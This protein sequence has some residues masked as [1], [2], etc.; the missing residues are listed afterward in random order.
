MRN[1]GTLIIMSCSMVTLVACSGGNSGGS[2]SSGSTSYGQSMTA[3]FIDAP[4]KGLKFS[5]ENGVNS[6]TGDLGKFSCKRGEKISFSLGGLDLGYAACGDKIFVQD[7]VSSAT[8]YN[9]QQAAAVLQTFSINKGTYLDLSLI[10]QNEIDLSGLSYEAV[11]ANLDLSSHLT[12]ALGSAAYANIP[13]AEKPSSAV[14]ASDAAVAANASLASHI[15]LSSQ[16]DSVLS[17]LVSAG[18]SAIELN[19]VLTSGT[20]V[21]GEEYCWAKIKAKSSIV[22]SNGYYSFKV[23]SA[24][25]YDEDE[26]LNQDGTCI[27]QQEQDG[28]CETSLSSELPSPKIITSERTDLISSGL[29]L[30]DP[31]FGGDIQSRSALSLNTVIGDNKVEYT[32]VLAGKMTAVSG[33][34]TGQSVSCQYS[35]AGSDV[36]TTDVDE[37]DPDVTIPVAGTFV[38]TLSCYDQGNLTGTYDAQVVV[39]GTHPS[40]QA[41]ITISSSGTVW[42]S[43]SLSFSEDIEKGWRISSTTN[44]DIGPVLSG[45]S[46]EGNGLNMN[47][48]VSFDLSIGDILST[49]CEAYDLQK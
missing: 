40:A 37:N 15:S 20:I 19:G 13:T 24:V 45:A 39:S 35:V 17:Q 1:L 42:A 30:N 10:D 25:S 14:S 31:E 29:I 12:T 4:V 16:L 27:L 33:P 32:G 34:F 7:L 21:N 44:A 48:Q 8:N 18:T 49:Y 43:S 41:A 26:V 23:E 22:S 2:S 5:T 28:E 9:W 36:V 6:A 3:Q 11:P 46:V 38:G 47:G